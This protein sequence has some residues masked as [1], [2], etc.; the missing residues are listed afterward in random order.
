MAH[1]AWYLICAIGL[2]LLYDQYVTPE[3]KREWENKIKMHHGEF[4]ALMVL[5]GLMT[6][7]PRLA[8]TGVGLALHDIDDANKWFTG[9]KQNL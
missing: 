5:F 2:A 7:S 1:W 4:G 8:A 3:Q 9:D 6:E